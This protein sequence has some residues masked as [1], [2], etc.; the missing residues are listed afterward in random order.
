MNLS[1]LLVFRSIAL[2]YCL[3]A[4]L[5]PTLGPHEL[6]H[7]R[8]PCPLLSPR[9]CSNSCPLSQW[10]HPTISSSVTPFSWSQSFP[11]SGSFPMSW[12]FTSGGQSIGASAS[13][14]SMNIH[15]W[16]PLGSIGLISLLS[17]GL[18]KVFF[19]TT[20]NTSVFR[21]SAFFMVQFSYLRF[22]SGVI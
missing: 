3:V 2:L 17:K 20:L 15:G 12:S 9:V 11:A 6:Q 7:G 19:S 10:C 1:S 16:F 5:C 4:K 22:C 18:S 14:F 21:Y 8:V 13:V